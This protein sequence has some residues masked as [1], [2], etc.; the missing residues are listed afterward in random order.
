VFD[1]HPLIILTIGI[2]TV[3]G[4]IIILRINAFIALITA[5]MVVSLLAPGDPAEK[6][7]RVAEAFGSMAGKIG[8]VIALAAVIGRCLIDSGAADRIVRLFVS[9]LG[10]KR[11]AISLMSSGFVLSVPVFFDTVFYLLVPLARSMYRRTQKN[12]LKFIM[13]IAAG[14]AITHTLVPPTPGPLIIANTLGVDLGVMII[15]GVIIAL[16]SSVAGILYAGWLN[17]RMNVPM[18]PI[19]SGKKEL[20]ALAENQLPGLLPSVLPIILPVLMIAT[21]TAVSALAK[22][23]AESS[24]LKYVAGL[25]AVPGNPNFAM[26]ISAAIAMFVFWRQRKPTKEELALVVETSLM[27]GGVIILITSAGGAFGSMLNNVEIGP[28]IQNMFVIDGGQQLGGLMLL[29]MGFFITSLIKIA[30]GS[31]T[32]AMITSSALF[33]AMIT[34]PDMLGYHPVY[35]ATTIASG[36]LFGCWLNDS[37]FWIFVKMSGLTEVEGLKSYTVLTA[38]LSLVGMAVTVL[39][40][41]FMPLV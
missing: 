36:S 4:M 39:M 1:L 34:S 14:A 16:P 21:H 9:L 13:A 12:Y 37:G 33:G 11:C 20:E 15:I 5:A 28:A 18:R 3:V 24:S 17:S 30:Q 35:L 6:I 23:A 7:S 32:V 29:G 25:T 2:L 40:A 26:L 10:E 38:I 31:S 41:T 27:S 19:S 22:G 8:V